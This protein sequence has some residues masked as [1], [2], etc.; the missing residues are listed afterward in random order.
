MAKSGSEKAGRP[1]RSQHFGLEDAAD[2]EDTLL[3]V[4]LSCAEE[5]D[6]AERKAVVR[7]EI[8]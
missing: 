3:F 5:A 8:E 1:K 7:Q 2:M 4:L 6:V